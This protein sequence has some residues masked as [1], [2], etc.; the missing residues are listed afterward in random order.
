ENLQNIVAARD[1]S[2]LA[3]LGYTVGI[4]FVFAL[5]KHFALET[6]ILYADRGY[7]SNLGL[8]DQLGNSIGN[9]DLKHHINYLEIPLKMNIALL[10][11]K[12]IHFFLSAG[13]SG[14]IFLFE[15][16]EYA[17]DYFSGQSEESTSRSN[18]NNL[19]RLNLTAL[20]GLGIDIFLTKRFS[21]RAEPIFRYALISAS[22]TPIK[23]YPYSFGA[24]LGLFL[25]L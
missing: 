7:R 5:R 19:N 15:N 23:Q 16:I 20:G 6:G 24:N 1:N 21:V 25:K 18:Q 22:D 3:K 2:E 9:A 13:L 10:A 8:V 12:R 17:F 14:N 11:K 4:R